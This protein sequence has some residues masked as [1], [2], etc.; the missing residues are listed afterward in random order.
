MMPTIYVNPSWSIWYLAASLDPSGLPWVRLERQK[1]KLF[2]HLTIA[3]T[4]CGKEFNTPSCWSSLDQASCNN[5]TADDNED[6][7][8]NNNDTLDNIA[9]S[10]LNSSDNIPEQLLYYNSSCWYPNHL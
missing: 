5:Y 2:P 3:F 9:V 1:A 10:S 8:K 4:R 6:T 7:F